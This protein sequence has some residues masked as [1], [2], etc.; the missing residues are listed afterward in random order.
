MHTIWP[1]FLKFLK[2]GKTETFLPEG[3][4]PKRV[5]IREIKRVFDQTN[6]TEQPNI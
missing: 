4:L 5:V 2:L 6:R 1:A 3:G